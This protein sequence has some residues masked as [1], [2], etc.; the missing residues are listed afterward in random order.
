MKKINIFG[1]T[2]SIGR[3]TLDVINF[4]S[5]S[6]EL[7]INALSASNNVELLANNSIVHKANYAV[8]TNPL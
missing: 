7:S 3:S 5:S 2:G 6:D 8:I 4:Q 1:V